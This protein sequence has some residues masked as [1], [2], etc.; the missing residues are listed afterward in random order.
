MR[1]RSWPDLVVSV[2]SGVDPGWS[3][4]SLGGTLVVFPVAASQ[5][6]VAAV[7]SSSAALDSAEL[8]PWG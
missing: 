7:S 5:R 8:E 6:T 4:S 1:P 3:S 2:D